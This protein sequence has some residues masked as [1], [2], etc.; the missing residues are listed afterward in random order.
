MEWTAE[1]VKQLTEQTKQTQSSNNAGWTADKVNKVLK[2]EKIGAAKAAPSSTKQPYIT[3]IGA[4]KLQPADLPIKEKPKAITFSPVSTAPIVYKRQNPISTLRGK[5]DEIGGKIGMGLLDLL[6]RTGNATV[7]TLKESGELKGIEYLNKNGNLYPVVKP[8]ATPDYGGAFIRGITGHDRPEALEMF[9]SKP[10]IEQAKKVSPVAAGVGEFAASGLADP[11]TYVGAGTFKPVLRKIAGK[12]PS[13]INKAEDALKTE[14]EVQKILDNE[15]FANL[16]QGKAPIN[17]NTQTINRPVQKQLD[18]ALNNTTRNSLI[19]S[20]RETVGLNTPSN[21]MR[22]LMGNKK[23]VIEPKDTVNEVVSSSNTTIPI[24]TNTS[25]PKN[26]PSIP[27]GLKER[28]FSKN[29]RTDAAMKDEIRNNFTKNPLT[30]EQLSNKMTLNKAT[31]RFNQGYEDALRDWSNSKATFSPDDIPLSRMLAN[32]AINR[33]DTET[34]RRILADSA[35]KLTQAGQYSQ[36][37]KILRESNDPGVF[38]DSLQRDVNKLNEQGRKQYGNKWNDVSLTDDELKTINGW[39]TANESSR[40]NMMEEVYN[41]IVQKIPVSRMEKF[42]AWR[43]MAMLLNPKT[44]AR[45]VFG[46][47]IMQGLRKIS[48]TIGA[49]LER[50][51]QVPVG[52]RTKSIGW[53]FDKNLKD[54]VEKAW[55]E[56]KK[57]LTQESRYDIESLS[58]LNRDKRIFKNKTLESINQFSKLALNAGDVPF[59]RRAYKDALGGY[60]KANRLV[61]VTDAA[62][63]YAKRRAFEATYKQANLL[64]NTLAKW[65]QQRG[66]G[67]LVEAAVPFSK[68]PTN[69]LKNSWEYSP[70]GLIQALYQKTTGKTPVVVIESLAKG[71]TGTSI[72]G[73]GFLLADMGWARGATSKSKNVEGT[74]QQLGEQPNSIITPL[75]SYTFDWAQPFAVPFAMGI[76]LQEQLSQ[77]DNIDMD[78]VVDSIASG[79]DTIFNMSM[80]QNIRQLI[81][82]GF[83]SVTEQIA[84]LPV[85]Y[86]EQAYPTVFGQTARTIDPIRRNTYD[87]NRLKQF[88]NELKAKTPGLS[89]TLEPKLDVFGR[90][91]KQG[92]AL[93]QFISP[94]YWSAK[95]NDKATQEIARLYKSVK[96][97]SI[98][99]KVAPTTISSKGKE[100]KLTPKQ[101]TEFQRIMG[102]K[103]HSDISRLVSSPAYRNASE[104]NK[105]KQLSKIVKHNYDDTKEKYLPSLK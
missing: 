73:L 95:T 83:G 48:D 63:E 35:E 62:K 67:K 30:Y 99:P 39:K 26:E 66:V 56:G 37:A 89:M 6:G 81:G 85:S 68:T 17:P 87:T 45:N 10:Q 32:E 29:V 15:Q 40:E 94:G 70:G 12:V 71:L 24:R 57:E 80:L 84:G 105:A 58:L 91:Q 74:L 61:G 16:I 55:Q 98:L 75:G 42:D 18:I 23:T 3:G 9:A 72:A 13:V 47:V 93:Q 38:M 69:I 21:R 104:E 60:M 79:S 27:E 44:H 4:Y 78:S 51:F 19:D 33:G 34:A 92:N 103:N 31:E 54:T 102:D 25:L 52:D 2:G 76:T 14:R 50:A 22:A 49:G 96:D 88:T 7:N 90:E 1:K 46:N 5:I 100:A 97:T 82:G 43:R 53:S 59:L 36:A 41:R 8:K 86:V 65:K 101:V 20:V 28:G 64:S 77:K 11:L